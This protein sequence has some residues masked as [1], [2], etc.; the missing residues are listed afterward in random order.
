[1]MVPFQDSPPYLHPW[2]FDLGCVKAAFFISKLSC[3]IFYSIVLYGVVQY[4]PPGC[5]FIANSV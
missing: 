3:V 4:C 1:M 5:R 2:T